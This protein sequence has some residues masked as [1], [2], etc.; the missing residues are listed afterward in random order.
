M[1]TFLCSVRTDLVVKLKTEIVSL[2]L[3]V[4]VGIPIM[5]V[6]NIP[7]SVGKRFSLPSNSFLGSYKSQNKK[8]TDVH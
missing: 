4:E 5:V 6:Q 8:G 1:S 2:K 3:L 7:Y